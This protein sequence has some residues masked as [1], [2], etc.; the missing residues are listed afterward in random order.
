[1][2]VVVHLDAAP[3]RAVPAKRQAP[4]MPHF[5]TVHDQRRTFDPRSKKNERVNAQRRQHPSG[6]AQEQYLERYPQHA[7]NLDAERPTR[8]RVLKFNPRSLFSHHTIVERGYG[9]ETARAEY[10]LTTSSRPFAMA[11]TVNR[12]MKSSRA[13][14]PMAPRSADVSDSHW[15]SRVSVPCRV[16][17]ATNPARFDSTSRHMLTLSEMRAGNPQPKAS[18]TAIPKFS[19]CDGNTN[20]SAL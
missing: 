7:P 3:Q 9:A 11:S 18:A 4:R 16:S 1:M 20:A 17:G 8:A 15:S 19:W 13:A 10:F 2:C 14:P 12:R 5:N 6:T